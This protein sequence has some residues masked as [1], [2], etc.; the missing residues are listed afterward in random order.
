MV[1]GFQQGVVQDLGMSID[2]RVDVLCIMV[3]E[4]V[5]VLEYFV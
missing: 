2:I 1:G 5:V 3:I 4:V